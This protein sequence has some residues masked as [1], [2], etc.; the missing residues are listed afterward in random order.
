MNTYDLYNLEKLINSNKLTEKPSFLIKIP[1][2]KKEKKEKQ[3]KPFKTK[4]KKYFSSLKYKYILLSIFSFFKKH[5]LMGFLYINLPIRKVI[6]SYSPTIKSTITQ[7]IKVLTSDFQSLDDIYNK[8]IYNIYKDLIGERDVEILS[9]Y[10]TFI[11]PIYINRIIKSIQSNNRLLKLHIPIIT[12]ETLYLSHDF[13]EYFHFLLESFIYKGKQFNLDLNSIRIIRK[14]YEN[15]DF[16]SDFYGSSQ[17]ISLLNVLLHDNPHVNSL[18]LSNLVLFNVPDMK[19]NR[20]LLYISF[21]GTSFSNSNWIETLVSYLISKSFLNRL[22]LSNCNMRSFH[23]KVLCKYL[24]NWKSKSLT[25]LNIDN[26]INIGTVGLFDLVSSLKISNSLVK[27]T[28]SNINPYENMDN[29]ECN[30]F[31]YMFSMLSSGSSLEYI[32]CSRNFIYKK[33]IIAL[34]D[35]L[36][37]GTYSYNIV[38]D[39][40]LK[41]I[42]LNSDYNES[43]NFS[44][45]YLGFIKKIEKSI[46]III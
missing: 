22:N 4:A 7:I 30:A 42:N 43:F 40:R 41:Y 46:K 31:M 27:L 6:L 39:C 21:E 35:M 26:N 16:I 3:R 14:T 36:I 2:K 11:Y 18:L 17:F 9:S 45:K 24:S 5:E 28:I 33:T 37:D 32:D 8:K 20:D 38:S 1:N 44:Q 29:E 15:H 13:V 12:D 10:S 25:E 34:L 19:K 23:I